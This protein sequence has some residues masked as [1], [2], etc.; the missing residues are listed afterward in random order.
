MKQI[1]FKVIKA[2]DGRFHIFCENLEETL[3]LFNLLVEKLPT[4]I[5]TKGFGLVGGLMAN[6]NLYGDALKIWSDNVSPFVHSVRGDKDKPNEAIFAIILD[7]DGDL[8][9][10]PFAK[11]Q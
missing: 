5:H 4:F 11:I 8:I 2:V 10:S 3:P 7:D 6:I 1:N 9:I